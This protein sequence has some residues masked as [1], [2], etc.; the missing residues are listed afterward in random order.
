MG[1]IIL[2]LGPHGV[3]KSTL[4]R[5]A[6]KNNLFD[7]YDG[8]QFSTKGYDLKH[9]P[10]FLEYQKQYTERI[11]S[12]NCLI[13][14]GKRPGLVNRSIEES[15]YYFYNFSERESAMREYKKIYDNEK[16]IKVDF[17]IY[18]DADIHTL[19]NRCSGDVFRDMQENEEWYEKEYKQYIEFWKNYP[20]VNFVNTVDK[21]TKTICDEIIDIVKER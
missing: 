3:G 17:I 20:G 2:I 4:F 21:D 18:L 19:Q 10:D 5:Y 8:F 13:K 15:A 16:N 7:V 11:N 6:E 12:E 14:I 1:K 9:L